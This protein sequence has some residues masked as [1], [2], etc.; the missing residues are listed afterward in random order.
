MRFASGLLTVTLLLLGGCST[1]LTERNVRRFVD[2]ADHAFLAGH[3]ADICNMRS[4]DFKFTGTTFKPA[5]GRTVSGLEE[6]MKIDRERQDAG[7][8]SSAEV[9]TMNARDYC[10]MAIVSRQLYRRMSLV[11]TSLEISVSP[12]HKQATVRAHY[13]VK[14]P[15]YVYDSSTLSRQDRVENQ[16]GTTQTE[17][18]EESVVTQNAQGKLVFS[19]THAT[20]W[21]FHVEKERDSRL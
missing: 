20:S 3:A 17:S 12:D 2:D 9:V 11:R 1:D 4:D 21:E 13:V 19:S 6:A 16:V 15:E 8:R 14:A 7:E 18:D 5:E 10:R